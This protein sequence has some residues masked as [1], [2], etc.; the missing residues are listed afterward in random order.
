[1][2]GQAAK[3]LQAEH[4]VDAVVHEF[5][6]FCGQQPAFASGVAQGEG[7]F[8]Q[9]G[10]AVNMGHGHNFVCQRG[11]RQQGTRAP[12]QFFH[13]ADGQSAAQGRQG[14]AALG[15]PVIDG[16]HQTVEHEVGQVR[17]ERFAAFLT[18][19]GHDMFI[20][21]LVV[22]KEDFAHHGHA[23]TWG[24]IQRDLFKIAQQAGHL[25]LKGVTSPLR[26]LGARVR[27]QAWV[28]SSVSPL[29]RS[30]VPVN[31]ERRWSISPPSMPRT[32]R[33]SRAREGLNP[34][35]LFA[36]EELSRRTGTCGKP[37]SR[38]AL[39]NMPG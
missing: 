23:R 30:W 18:N 2:V 4:V 35:W 29:W 14:S 32:M 28:R 15:P 31:S 25:L 3:G 24:H 5:Q 6:H 21:V 9:L 20:G 19:L 34:G 39:R 38:S 13:P 16:I 7:L 37:H 26:T 11:A 1:M 22:G 36:P 8:A 17:Q 33:P 12:A 10:Q 27:S